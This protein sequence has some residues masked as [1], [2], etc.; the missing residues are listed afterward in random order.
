M[1]LTRIRLRRGSAADWES[2][3]PVLALGEAGVE[4][5]RR[6]LKSGD[7]ATAWTDLGYL[8]GPHVTV[9]DVTAHGAAVDGTT[10]DTQAWRDAF[11]AADPANGGVGVV[12]MPGGVSIVSAPSGELYAFTQPEGVALVGQGKR[13]STIRT[14]PAAPS[15]ENNRVVLANADCTIMGVTIDNNARNNGGADPG[16]ADGDGHCITSASGANNISIRHVLCFDARNYGINPSSDS[17][18]G[19]SNDNWH[20]IDVEVV[21][22]GWDGL[23]AK[24]LHDSQ[25]A[26]VAAINC[27]RNGLDLRP[28]RCTVTDVLAQDCGWEGIAVLASRTSGKAEAAIN[29]A[30]VRNCGGANGRSGIRVFYDNTYATAT[31]FV[32]LSNIISRGNAQHGIFRTIQSTVGCHTQ[33]DNAICDGNTDSGIFCDAGGDASVTGSRLANNGGYGFDNNG[34]DER[35]LVVG[36]IAYGNTSGQIRSPAASALHANNLES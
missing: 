21:D 23:D 29:G 8:R 27:G 7:G 31:G 24:A 16:G 10:D 5:D 18:A 22:C 2:A 34:V 26:K 17:T 28:D 35:H 13:V 11:S 4:T 30:I 19:E 20:I 3:N 6:R 12:A 1:T 25:I 36:N 15:S 33:I 9:E 14:D 32:A